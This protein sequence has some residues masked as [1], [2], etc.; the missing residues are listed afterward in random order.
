MDKVLRLAL[1]QLVMNNGTLTND[2]KY[3]AIAIITNCRYDDEAKLFTFQLLVPHSISNSDESP[4]LTG[5]LN[6]L[7]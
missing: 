2:M 6:H 4:Y 3:D 1:I 5:Q 7:F